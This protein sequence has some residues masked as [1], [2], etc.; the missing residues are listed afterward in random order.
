VDTLLADFGVHDAGN[1]VERLLIAAFFLV[2]T[3]LLRRVVINL[4]FRLLGKIAARTES[5]LDDKLFPALQAPAGALVTVSGIFAALAVLKFSPSVDRAIGYGSTVAFSLVVFWGLYRAFGAVLD[6]AH[7]VAV[8]RQLGV[9]AFMP[10]IKKTL[11]A[12]FIG[13]GALLIIQSLG[14]NVSTILQGLGIGGLAFALAAQDTIANL[15]GSIVV[16][17]DQPF[18]IGETVTIGAHTGTVEDIG[19]RSTKLRRTDKSLVVIPNRTVANEAIINLSRF[20]ARRVEQV[21]TLTYDA[22]PEDMEGIVDDIRGIINAEPGVDQ[23]ATQVY[24][25]DLNQ[26]SLDIWSVYVVNHP[27]FDRHMVVRQRVNVAIMRAVAARGLSFAFPTQ[28]M[29]LPAP[30]VDKLTDRKNP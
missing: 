10:W 16:A 29:H 17:V 21:F 23:K 28:T 27:D 8:D 3:L 25:R 1:P 26:S 2:V 4:V 30:V 22:K 15:F 20:T 13:I 19:L 7:E 11:A 6:H 14:Y 18:R 9:A 12:M 5:T 24:F